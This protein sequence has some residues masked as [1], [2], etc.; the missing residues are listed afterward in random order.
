MLNVDQVCAQPPPHGATLPHPQTAITEDFLK[1]MSDRRQFEREEEL[2]L[3]DEAQARVEAIEQ[4]M[5]FE[6]Q[7]LSMSKEQ[8]L[9][10]LSHLQAT[11]ATDMPGGVGP[12]G[13]GGASG[14]S[15]A[16]A[17]GATSPTASRIIP[18]ISHFGAPH[19][20]GGGGASTSSSISSGTLYR[21]SGPNMATLVRGGHR[22]STERAAGRTALRLRWSSNNMTQ[23]APPPAP[24]H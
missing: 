2:R 4:Q 6:E 15:G 20:A 12:G 5:A 13:A 22:R 11:M 14:G 3:A 24:P 21:I 19:R 1:K 10:A 9:D 17:A 23:P 7:R 16:G 18:P 8:R